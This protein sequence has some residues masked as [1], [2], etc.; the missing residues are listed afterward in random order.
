MRVMIQGPHDLFD[1]VIEKLK[2]NHSF[3]QDE[4]FGRIKISNE[5][6]VIR[7]ELPNTFL[8]KNGYPIDQDPTI[9]RCTFFPDSKIE[10][11]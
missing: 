7:G 11:I 5:L 8:G 4:K 3:I 9:N 1:E 2:N 10:L 6:T